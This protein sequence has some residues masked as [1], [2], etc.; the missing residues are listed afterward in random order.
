MDFIK[1]VSIQKKKEKIMIE[2]LK[3]K[4]NSFRKLSP[5]RKIESSSNRVSPSKEYPIQKNQLKVQTRISSQI[6]NKHHSS[7]NI[8]IL[9]KNLRKRENKNVKKIVPPFNSS[10]LENEILQELYALGFNVEKTKRPERNF[11]KEK[12]AQVYKEDASSEESL[13]QVR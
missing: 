4:Q 13:K 9:A 7:Q 1:Q 8:D 3:M 2:E 11:R 6:T 10:T 5:I 12:L